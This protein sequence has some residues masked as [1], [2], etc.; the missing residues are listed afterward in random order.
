MRRLPSKTLKGFSAFWF[1]CKTHLKGVYDK[2]RDLKGKLFEQDLST[3]CD[4][5]WPERCKSESVAEYF[6]NLV[7]VL[8]RQKMIGK[9]KSIKLLRELKEFSSPEKIGGTR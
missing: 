3:R 9:K 1:L 5:P 2:T 8:K 6:P 7:K 4:Y